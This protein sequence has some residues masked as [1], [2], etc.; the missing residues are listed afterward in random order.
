MPYSRDMSGGGERRRKRGVE[1]RG[2][3]AV[4]RSA[5][6]YRM[7]DLCERAGLSRQ[8]VHFYIQQGLLPEGQK[9]GRNMAF[10]SEQH[11]KRLSLIRQLQEE[12]FLPLRAIRA[13]LGESEERFTPKQRELITEI[14]Q[15]LGPTLGTE[16]L[17][18][19]VGADE[20]LEETGVRGSDLE[21][22]VEL[23]ILAT[24]K[25]GGRTVLARDDTFI[26][27]LWSQLKEAG[28]TEELGFQVDDLLL[29]SKAM[30]KL[31]VG[32]AQLLSD[33]LTGRL[34]PKEAAAMVERVLP[35][36]NTFLVHYHTAQ[37][38]NFLAMHR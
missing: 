10:Y 29:Y 33:R 17:P 16:R 37:V 19:T 38:R 22:M 4:D 5:F 8:V 24:S 18:D 3:V 11:L 23:G 9:T 36:I 13:M 32:E 31:F 25:Q 27:E 30:S 6:P 28:F 12:R 35:I 7:K 14:R 1:Q 26:V 2:K 15:R 34:P 20:L 21:R